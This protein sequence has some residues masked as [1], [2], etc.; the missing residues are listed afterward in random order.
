[1]IH[2]AGKKGGVLLS[3]QNKG[4]GKAL[5]E[6]FGLKLPEDET[7]GN[8]VA[9]MVVELSAVVKGPGADMVRLMVRSV[10]PDDEAQ[11]CRDCDGNL[12]FIVR[13]LGPFSLT[14]YDCPKCHW[15]TAFSTADTDRP[16]T[17]GLIVGEHSSRRVWFDGVELLPGESQLV[18]N[19]SPDG[20][21]W[22]YGG[23]G[24]TQ[25]A[26]AIALRL[27]TKKSNAKLVY[28]AF[29]RKWIA[30]LGKDRDFCVAILH[31]SNWL[32]D[33]VGKALLGKLDE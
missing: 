12:R 3:N 7:V 10:R 2:A 5:V 21:A 19:H 17:A 18:Y 6:T 4:G 8:Y 24:P 31:V 20:F 32:G 22:G 23:S 11:K 27:C 29:G 14:Y 25:L 13:R 33:A 15:L 26:L 1:M 30:K 9:V 16:E 28:R